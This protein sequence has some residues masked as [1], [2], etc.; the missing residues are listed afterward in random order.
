MATVNRHGDVR[1]IRAHVRQRH[2]AGLSRFRRN[3]LWAG[4]ASLTLMAPASADDGLSPLVTALNA[5]N[6]LP[7]IAL[8]FSV[9]D[10]LPDGDIAKGIVPQWAFALPLTQ[11]EIGAFTAAGAYLPLDVA[12]PECHGPTF[13][14]ELAHALNGAAAGAA[15][16][17]GWQ[18]GRT[19]A[20][21]GQVGGLPGCVRPKPRPP[22]A[23]RFT[24]LLA[25]FDSCPGAFSSLA[26]KI[27]ASH[28]D[29]ALAD[30]MRHIRTDRIEFAVGP[31]PTCAKVDH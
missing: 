18:Q 12:A 22:A 6:G 16:Y 31:D 7:D 2:W 27:I 25:A 5:Y 23:P 13:G 19:G 3:F 4:C 1:R 21:T 14:S 8:Q 26:Q 9:S 20:P 15:L 30:L 29:S 24:Q 28:P 11:A 10:K 17:Q